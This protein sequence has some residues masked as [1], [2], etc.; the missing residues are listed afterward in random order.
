L[1]IIDKMK[2]CDNI[3]RVNGLILINH[4]TCDICDVC[5]AVCPANAIRMD[6]FRW[7][8]DVQACNGCQKCIEVCPLGA[9]TSG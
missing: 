6:H 7:Y 3:G 2:S 5:T 9:L 1:S 8:L 4:D